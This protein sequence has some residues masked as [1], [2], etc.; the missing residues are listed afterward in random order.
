MEVVQ[1]IMYTCT[2]T[3]E[4]LVAHSCKPIWQSLK[5]IEFSL[6]KR[7]YNSKRIASFEVRTT[8]HLLIESAISRVFHSHTTG[9]HSC[10]R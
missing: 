5:K 3:T 4:F 10:D 6:I 8:S 7:K 9:S 2:G 1:F